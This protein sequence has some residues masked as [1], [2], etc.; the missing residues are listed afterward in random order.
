MPM[1]TCDMCCQFWNVLKQLEG[2]RRVSAG[3]S[4]IT[5]MLNPYEQAREA[6][7]ARNNLVLAEL[8]VAEKAAEFVSSLSNIPKPRKPRATKVKGCEPSRR[9]DRNTR[10]AHSNLS[11][12]LLSGGPEPKRYTFTASRRRFETETMPKRKAPEHEFN[13]DYRFTNDKST[14]AARLWYAILARQPGMTDH[15]ET[16]EQIA[17]NLGE[18]WVYPESIKG[19]NNDMIKRVTKEAFTNMSPKLGPEACVDRVLELLRQGA[20]TGNSHFTVAATLFTML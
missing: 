12:V 4:A 20:S 2:Q 8:K 13:D 14:A 7:I 9:S 11:E 18:Q 6:R 1:G 19:A 5:I 17:F 3:D 15:L 10:L 16:C